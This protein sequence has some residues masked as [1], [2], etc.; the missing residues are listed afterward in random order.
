MFSEHFWHLVLIL[1]PL[2]FY[3]AIWLKSKNGLKAFNV[4]ILLILFPFTVFHAFPSALILEHHTQMAA[5]GDHPCC[6]PIIDAEKIDL[7]VID[8][9]PGRLE[10]VLISQS[11]VLVKS[12]NNK[13]PPTIS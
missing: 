2:T 9:H 3:G 1:A 6:I 12:L 10:K 8:I 13:S 7:S 5:H 4:F 11:S